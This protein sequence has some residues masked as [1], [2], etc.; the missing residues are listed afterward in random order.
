MNSVL[1]VAKIPMVVGTEFRYCKKL[2]FNM[3]QMS[4]FGLKPRH[5]S[6]K[7]NDRFLG[8]EQVVSH[9][10]TDHFLKSGCKTRSNILFFQKRLLKRKLL[11]VII[12]LL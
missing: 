8:E 1:S 4:Y 2:K 3:L 11:F 7:R 12:Y 9:R 6:F 10:E 5:R